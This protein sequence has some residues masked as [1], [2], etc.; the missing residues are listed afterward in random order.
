MKSTFRW[1]RKIALAEGVSF[2][3]LLFIAMPLKYWA[4]YP[5]A[6]TV[7]GGIHG[8]LFVAF[9]VMALETKREYKLSWGWF[10][11]A[12]IASILPFGTFV[13]EKEWKRTEAQA[14]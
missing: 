4:G 13:M 9:V 10:V 6:V 14:Q 8:L 7:V 11:K 1:F 5:M 3:L 12:F 2:L